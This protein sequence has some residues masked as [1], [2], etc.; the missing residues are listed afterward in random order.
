MGVTKNPRLYGNRLGLTIEGK[1]Y[2]SDLGKYE[3]AEKESDKDVLTFAD[4]AAG[5]AS[6]WTLKGSAIISFAAGSF[7]DLVWKSKGKTLGFILAPHGN[8]TATEDK[9]HFTGK[10][11][12]TS[13]PPISSE[14]GDEK[15][16]VFDFEWTTD[17]DI[18]KVTSE[19]TLGT[20]NMD[21][22]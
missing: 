8:K 20:G 18:A 11:K 22:E 14:A 4:A 1:D 12:I 10:V 6:S 16:A 2:W 9:P 5:G 7:W 15:G 19:S 21:D 13:R 17:G 3:L